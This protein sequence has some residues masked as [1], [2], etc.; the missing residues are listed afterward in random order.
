MY[1]LEMIA[2]EQLPDNKDELKGIIC[3]LIDVVEE[4]KCLIAN[5]NERIEAQFLKMEEQSQQIHSQSQKIDEQSQQIH[6]QSQKI[7]EQ[8]QRIDQLTDQV[9]AL[10]RYRYGK[11]SE[12]IPEEKIKTDN[13]ENSPDGYDCFALL[14]A[15]LAMTKKDGTRT[16]DL[17]K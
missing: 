11:R 17:V 16:C 5:Q 3:Q 15:G 14:S 8:S 4:Q 10:K 13:V 7:E 2:R 6:L 1:T 9:N 12:K